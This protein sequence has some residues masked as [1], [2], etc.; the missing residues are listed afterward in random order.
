MVVPNAMPQE[1]SK[2]S[3]F[4]KGISYVANLS[5]KE[6]V[7][8]FVTLF[9]LVRVLN[10]STE[11][12][13]S[14]FFIVALALITYA[15]SYVSSVDK[16]TAKNNVLAYIQDIENKVVKHSTPEMVLETVY[17]LHKPLKSLRFVKNNEEASELVYNLRYLDIY[18]HEL[19][20]DFIIY[21][22]YFLKLHFN[23]MIGKYDIDT[24]YTILQDVRYELL[25]TLQSYHFKIP[26]YSTTFDG[27]N[28]VDRLSI[29]IAKLQ[30]LTYRYM[31]ILHKKYQRKLP[32][33]QYKGETAL[34]KLK[35]NKYHIY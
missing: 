14:S 20:F 32:H 17:K 25:N 35:S 6:K 1:E 9:G 2:G 8:I 29:S 5:N 24:N 19:Y 10:F 27:G 3:V 13:N 16:R 31:K 28:L 4:A 12:D 23:M 21:L 15:T 33:A 34:D 30:A 18:E 7:L 11:T 26:D 22:E